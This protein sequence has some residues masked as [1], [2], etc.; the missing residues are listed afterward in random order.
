MKSRKSGSARVT[1]SSPPSPQRPTNGKLPPASLILI[2]GKR[3]SEETR[4]F[5][6]TDY[7]ESQNRMAHSK[8]N[9]HPRPVRMAIREYISTCIHHVYVVVYTRGMAAITAGEIWNAHV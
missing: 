8:Y 1:S 6:S 4:R 2:P 7:K 5:K 9:L 3:C